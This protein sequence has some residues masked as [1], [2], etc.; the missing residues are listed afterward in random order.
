[1]IYSSVA[2]IS[3]RECKVNQD[4]TVKMDKREKG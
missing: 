3:Y 1:M 2:L 4:T